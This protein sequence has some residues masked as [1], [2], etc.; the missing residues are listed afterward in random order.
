MKKDRDKLKKGM[1]Q[2]LACSKD[3]PLSGR[4]YQPDSSEEKDIKPSFA[5]HFENG[6]IRLLISGVEHVMDGAT[7][8]ILVNN[9]LTARHL[10]MSHDSDYPNP[11]PSGIYGCLDCG[12]EREPKMV[13]GWMTCPECGSQKLTSGPI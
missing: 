5:A 12:E 3:T 9:L 10:Q 2:I 8:D 4:Y 7:C 6:K 13:A 1:E 11:N